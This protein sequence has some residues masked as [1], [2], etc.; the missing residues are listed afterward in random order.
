MK[1]HKN[2]LSFTIK[3]LRAERQKKETQKLQELIE[4]EGYRKLHNWLDDNRNASTCEGI[5][6]N[7]EF[8]K[9]VEP[10][11]D[12]GYCEICETKTVKS[13]LILAGVI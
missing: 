13:G 12:K 11:Q 9:E 2:R 5:C 1:Y 6:M 10:H 3:S 8:T 7:C 4:S